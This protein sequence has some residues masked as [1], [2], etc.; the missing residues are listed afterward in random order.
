MKISRLLNNLLQKYVFRIKLNSIMLSNAIIVGLLS[1]P[2]LY[3]AEVKPS[4]QSLTISADLDKNALPAEVVIFDNIFA[5]Q[6]STADVS[7]PLWAPPATTRQRNNILICMTPDVA[8]GYCR[9]TAYWGSLT[10][11]TPPILGN[12]ISLQFKQKG[13][14]KTEILSLYAFRHG[15]GTTPQSPWNA[16]APQNLTTPIT[17]RVTIPKTELAKLTPGTKDQPW[18]GTLYTLLSEYKQCPTWNTVQGCPVFGASS[19]AESWVATITLTF[20]ETGK[21]EI[22][23]PEF[24]TG[25]PIIDLGSYSLASPPTGSV[26]KDLDM[27][28]YDGNNSSAS[29]INLLF[30]DEGKAAPGRSAGAFS[31][32]NPNGKTDAANRIDYTL[33]IVDPKTGMLS[34]IKNGT[35]IQWT[36]V[37]ANEGKVKTRSVSIPGIPGV[38]QCVPAPLTFTM[39]KFLLSSKEKGKYSGKLN[40]IYSTGTQ[41]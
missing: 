11:T 26:N 20:T 25:Q 36:G 32:Y 28:L 8:F 14:G 27:C 37:S 35:Q 18:Q 2:G 22:F 10:A 15:A 30:S 40:I 5:G 12:T 23:F 4:S 41:S 38:V 29:Q 13:T 19:G 9:Q 39:P 21:Q 7:I 31:I 34:P 1:A 24:G 17:M 3:A 16:A 6:S 33:S